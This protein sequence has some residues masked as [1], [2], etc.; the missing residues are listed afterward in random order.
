MPEELA[1]RKT[2]GRLATYLQ[3]YG[4]VLVDANGWSR[5]DL[6]PVPGGPAGGRLPGSLRRGRD[7]RAADLPARRG[8]PRGSGWRPRRPGLPRQCAARIADQ[9]AAGADSVI[10]HGATPTELA[11]VVRGLGPGP[12][13]RPVR[14]RCPPT[15]AGCADDRRGRDRARAA[16]LGLAQRGARQ[17]RRGGLGRTGGHRSDRCLL[18]R[19]PGG[20]R[21]A[22]VAAGQAPGGRSRHP[23]DARRRL[24]RRGH[25]LRR[26]R[27][28]RGRDGA[29]LLVRRDAAG[30]GRVHA[31]PP[32][33]RSGRAG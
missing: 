22:D 6:D 5:D 13:P 29:A 16:H 12:G 14:R 18:P 11:P 17:D 26:P 20:A 27:R 19:R 9:L 30:H 31:A 15:P 4:Q 8:D 32:G 23:R 21:L 7:H 28:H 25:L 2:V 10:L 24:P 3:G 33:P 1:L